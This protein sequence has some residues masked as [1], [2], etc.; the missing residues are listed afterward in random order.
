[1]EGAFFCVDLC[2]DLYILSVASMEPVPDAFM[3]ID[4]S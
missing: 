3:F 1:M 4:D 2:F